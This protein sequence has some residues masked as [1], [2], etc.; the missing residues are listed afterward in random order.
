VQWCIYAQQ[1]LLEMQQEIRH[2]IRGRYQVTESSQV[3]CRLVFLMEMTESP[4]DILR[5]NF[6]VAV[7]HYAS[8]PGKAMPQLIINLHVSSRAQRSFALTSMPVLIPVFLPYEC[9]GSC[10]PLLKMLRS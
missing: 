3:Y 9:H 7:A 4:P 10:V 1:S 6:G 5:A 2:C 8:A